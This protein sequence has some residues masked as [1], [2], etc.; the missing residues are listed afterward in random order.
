MVS[1]II[2]N[3]NHKLY[4]PKR[5]ES[6]LNQSYQNFELIILDDCSTDNSRDILEKYK[7]HPKVSHIV[8]NEKNS[9][10]T[11]K[12]WNKGI[13]LAKAD[14]IWIAES[15][16]KADPRFL[17]SIVP[18]MNKNET[19]G[20]GY[21][22]SYKLNDKEEITG[23][24]LDWTNSLDDKKFLHDFEMDGLTYIQNYL[25][26]KNTIP[27]ASGAVFRK[28]YYLAVGGAD[29]TIKNCS[30][31]C[32]WLKI[33]LISDVLYIKE[34]LNYFRYHDQSVIAMASKQNA[35]LGYSEVYDRTMRRKFTKYLTD[36]KV[37][38]NTHQE[39]LRENKKYIL[40]DDGREGLFQ[41]S[42]GNWVIG[43]LTILRAYIAGSGSSYIKQLRD[44]VYKKFEKQFS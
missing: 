1:V 40:E 32:T 10:S 39:M 8:Y 13:E 17:A 41:I 20:I 44:K 42:N 30:D 16:D 2:P 7:A 5:I 34:P 37:K 25:I 3:Y 23:N 29:E 21:C 43:S 24:W 31:W 35:Q 14:L 28:K 18:E 38:N 19:I 11:F 6:I 33:L 9:G 15:D 12:Q 27:N 4:L 36:N 22:Q 26:H